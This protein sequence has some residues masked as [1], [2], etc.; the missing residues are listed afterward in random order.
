MKLFGRVRGLCACLA[1]AAGLTVAVS[2]ASGRRPGPPTLPPDEVRGLWVLR[3][4]LASRHAIDAM[5][6]AARAGGFNTILVQVRGRGEAYYRSAIDPRASELDGQPSDFDPLAVTL[7][8]AHRADL[9]VHAWVS[10]NLV[11]SATTLP[12]SRDHVVS[13]HPDWLMVP[14]P[15]AGELR[16]VDGRSPAYVGRLARWT[17]AASTQVEGLY[18]SPIPADSQDYSASVVAELAT[19]YQIDGVHLDYLRYPNEMFD[20]SRRA[21]EDFR[22]T[23]AAQVTATQRQQLDRAALIEPAAWA[24]M[25]PD[26]WAAFRR[27]RL[28]VL[29]R[30]LHAVTRAARPG[31]VISVAVIPSAD[32]AADHRFQE[33]GVWA[34]SGLL[35]VVCPMAYTPELTEFT[36][37]ITR[38]RAA[39]GNTPV[40][41]GIGAWRLPAMRTTDQVRAARKLGVAGVVL[42]SYDQLASPASYFERIW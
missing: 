1:L 27:E 25:F 31:A 19:R 9:R 13:R 14:R 34:S 23:R 5:V 37:L 39:A 26:G 36:D 17:R 29:L 32:D 20:Y 4:S 10:V 2:A 38:A 18:L 6:R 11:A 7:D 40:W 28:T 12:R 33:W 15:L 21:L 35:D 8:L 41:A 42:F 22:A 16:T 30:R 24:N 3:S